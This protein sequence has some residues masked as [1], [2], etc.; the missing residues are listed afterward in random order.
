MVNGENIS[1]CKLKLY[2]RRDIDSDGSIRAGSARLF[3]DLLATAFDCRSSQR[4]YDYSRPSIRQVGAG[5]V[6]LLSIGRG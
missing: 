6:E 1:H 2:I 3:V 4:I 5:N